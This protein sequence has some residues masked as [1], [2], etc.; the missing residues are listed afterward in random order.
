MRAELGHSPVDVG[1]D[2]LR[3]DEQ[4]LGDV[5]VGQSLRDQ[6]ENLAFPV[7][8]RGEPGGC[9]QVAVVGAGQEPGDEAPGGGGRQ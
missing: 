8:Q 6:G 4:A 1:L 3:A 5:V 2:G 7:G 9:Q